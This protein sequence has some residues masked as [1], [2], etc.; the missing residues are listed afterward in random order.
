MVS[1]YRASDDVGYRLTPLY[2]ALLTKLS[3][4]GTGCGF[5]R[6]FRGHRELDPEVALLCALLHTTS[7][8]TLEVA[9]N[10]EDFAACATERPVNLT[11]S[12]TGILCDV[13][14]TKGIAL[15]G[16]RRITREAKETVVRESDE[17]TQAARP[18]VLR[19]TVIAVGV[20]AAAVIV[21]AIIS[22][23][24]VGWT[25]WLTVSPFVILVVA[26]ISS[27]YH[28]STTP[29]MDRARSV[30]M[31]LAAPGAAAV[32]GLIVWSVE[33]GIGNAI[34]VG[35]AAGIGLGV[36]T[37]LIYAKSRRR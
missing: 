28:K 33:G 15:M 31:M 24:Q 34:R 19:D 18:L 6:R 1:A 29:E 10:G 4:V 35:A 30:Q 9:A 2:G 13:R 37:A 27:V 25:F 14:S 5:V 12:A 22:P 32:S 16:M 7:R 3:Q 17:R 20:L 11:L 8:S 23:G 21:R 26:G 36:V